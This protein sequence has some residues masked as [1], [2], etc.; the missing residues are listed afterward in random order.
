MDETELEHDLELKVAYHLGLFTGT[1]SSQ[2]GPDRALIAHALWLLAREAERQ[3]ERW[4]KK[5]TH[6]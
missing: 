1:V 6:A 4:L 5:G 2:H 3:R